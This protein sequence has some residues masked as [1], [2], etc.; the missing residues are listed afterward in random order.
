VL[1][2]ELISIPTGF[3][4]LVGMG[5]LWKA[6]SV[7]RADALPSGVLLQLPWRDLR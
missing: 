2:T 6:K 3:I 1:T 7:Y 5:T 4:F